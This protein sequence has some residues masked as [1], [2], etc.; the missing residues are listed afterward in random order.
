MVWVRVSVMVPKA[1]ST[2]AQRQQA[3]DLADNIINNSPGVV[4]SQ[5]FPISDPGGNWPTF[6]VSVVAWDDAHQTEA[7]T[8]HAALEAS[9]SKA[10]F[11]NAIEHV[12]SIQP[13]KR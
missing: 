6:G 10:A 4:S 12:R 8:A 7:N 2:H 11:K 1:G 13:Y 9:H 5:F 3:K